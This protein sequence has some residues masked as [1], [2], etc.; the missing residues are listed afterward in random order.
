MVEALAA[1][2]TIV[3]A[4]ELCLQSMV[5]ESV[6]HVSSLFPLLLILHFI[7]SIIDLYS[8]VGTVIL[9][10]GCLIID[11]LSKTQKNKKQ[12]KDYLNFKFRKTQRTYFLRRKMQRI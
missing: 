9:A 4:K 2:R 7:F 10:S 5:V 12:N 11:S 6:D 1:S 8:C 3:F